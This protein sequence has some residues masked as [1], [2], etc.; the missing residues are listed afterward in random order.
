MFP[1]RLPDDGGKT[2]TVHEKQKKSKNNAIRKPKQQEPRQKL[3]ESQQELCQEPQQKQREPRQEQQ[4]SA[5]V[6]PWIVYFAVVPAGVR[7][8]SFV[9]RVHTAENGS[10]INVILEQVVEKVRAELDK[11]QLKPQQ[12]KQ[13]V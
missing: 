10:H 8:V 12:I 3:Q 7:H 6:F 13:H 4:D 11:Q 9:N 2:H 1:D 5:E